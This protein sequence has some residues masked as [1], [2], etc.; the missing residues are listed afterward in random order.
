M[1]PLL[2]LKTLSI[3]LVL[4]AA[5]IGGAYPYYKKW[6]TG[7]FEFP[8][9]EALA[10][11]IFLGAGLL[12]MLGDAA[13]DFDHLHVSY[14]YP[15]LIAGITFL[16]FLSLEHIGREIFE[17]KGQNTKVFAFV[18]LIMLSIHSF[19]TGTALG[20]GESSSVVFIILIAI[21]AHKS[22]ASLAL[23]T[24]INKSQ[25]KPKIGI[26]LFLIF[27]LMTPLGIILGEVI[28]SLLTKN[29]Y[30]E[31]TFNAIAAGTFIYLGTLHGLSRS[32]MVKKCCNLKNFFFV[33]L[34]FSIMAI[35]A[36]WT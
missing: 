26:G 20:L 28:N 2:L 6:K 16:F 18:T 10:S 17:H 27:A 23:A 9:G 1:D 11:G 33:L 4:V 5:I 29:V 3:G 25:L 8:I 32:F 7:T 24:Q 19:L 22:A 21:L 35:V 30:L 36:I 31:P 12:H 14:P 13:K 15:F 34:G